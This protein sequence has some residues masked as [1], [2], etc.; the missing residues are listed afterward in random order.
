Y[1]LLQDQALETQTTISA[2]W[3]RGL[4]EIGHNVSDLATATENT[5]VNA[6]NSAEDALVDFVTTGKVDFKSMVDSILAD[7]TRLIFKMT[8]VKALESSSGGGGILGSLAGALG[9]G[10]GGYPWQN[11]YL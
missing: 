3:Q 2:G 4:N 6:F 7:L 9:A 8:I 10:G 5:L 1:R 11:V